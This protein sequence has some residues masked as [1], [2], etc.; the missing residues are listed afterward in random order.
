MSKDGPPSA[1]F[2]WENLEHFFDHVDRGRRRHIAEER[3]ARMQDACDRSPGAVRPQP[4]ASA[5]VSRA[6]MTA[7]LQTLDRRQL[8]LQIG[9]NYSCRS[10]PGSWCSWSLG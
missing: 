10:S 5:E 2:I 7:D 9:D 6:Q 1:R 4:I 8:L 3:N